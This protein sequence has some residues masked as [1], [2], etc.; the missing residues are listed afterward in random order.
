V[1][2]F[3]AYADTY[4]AAIPL[5]AFFAHRSLSR[6]K[7][8]IAFYLLVSV[9]IFGLSNYLADRGINNSI[10]YHAFSVIELGLI[11]YYF[12]VIGTEFLVKLKIVPIFISFLGLA[13]INILF[14]EDLKT[15]NSNTFFIE[16]LIIVSLC[17]VY[18]F[19]LVSSEKIEYCHK[20][21]SFWIVTAFFIYHSLTLP[22]VVFYGVASADYAEFI[23]EFWKVQIVLFLIKN[24]FILI[25]LLCKRYQ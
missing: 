2:F 22:I 17:F 8:V 24:F 15:W 19:R 23:L 10:L 13:I 25:G 11:L 6:E 5:A 12:K 9:I 7:K 20:I 3:W 1:N 14:F 18:F 4:G 16:F 21:S